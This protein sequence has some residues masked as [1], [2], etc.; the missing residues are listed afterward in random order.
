MNDSQPT[1]DSG[2]TGSGH[3]DWD[4]ETVVEQVWTDLG[5][6]VSRPAIRR[7]VAEVICAFEDARITTY[8]PLF[9]RKRTVERLR[10]GP[11]RVSMGQGRRAGDEV[12]VVAGIAEP[13][14]ARHDLAY[15]ALSTGDAQNARPA[16]VDT[17]ATQTSSVASIA[18][19]AARSWLVLTDEG[20][21]LTTEE[22]VPVPTP[23]TL[24]DAGS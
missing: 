20:L 24:D 8:V 6:T 9:V 11:S 15:A 21:I 2:A 1:I 5:G 12:A 14:E 3:P 22:P 23:A 16:P 13:L 7:E 10:I 4:V 18:E 19:D 17:Q